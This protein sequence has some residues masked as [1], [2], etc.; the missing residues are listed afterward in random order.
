MKS[1]TDI[2]EDSPNV[3]I[4]KG[5]LELLSKDLSILTKYERIQ[6][7][8][9]RKLLERMRIAKPRYKPIPEVPANK[10]IKIQRVN[11]MSLPQ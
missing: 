8:G 7:T 2:T 10:A 3:Y 6:A 5:M 4:T 9:I 11:R 1:F